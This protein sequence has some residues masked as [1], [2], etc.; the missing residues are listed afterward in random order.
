MLHRARP[1]REK[2]AELTKELTA[3]TDSISSEHH[4]DMLVTLAPPAAIK[5]A[6][7]KA[8]RALKDAQRRLSQH[9]ANS[10]ALYAEVAESKADPLPDA[11]VRRTLSSARQAVLKEE[12]LLLRKESIPGEIATGRRKL[13]AQ[14]RELALEARRNW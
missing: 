8:V 10:A 7:S 14:L 12:A 5:T 2:I 4:A 11:N 1:R 6:T 13:A 9:R 3:V